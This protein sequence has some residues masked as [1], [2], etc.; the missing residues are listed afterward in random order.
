MSCAPIAEDRTAPT[1]GFFRPHHFFHFFIYLLNHFED[2]PG[3]PFSTP[4]WRYPRGDCDFYKT[5]L[6]KQGATVRL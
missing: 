5:Y 2:A 3:V 6:S 4:F 1:F